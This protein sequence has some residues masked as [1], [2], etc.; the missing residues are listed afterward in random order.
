MTSVVL[1]SASP[2]RRELIAALI[3][4]FEVQPADVAEWLD[5]DPVA[6]AVALATLKAEAVA[7]ERPGCLVIAADTIVHD[8]ARPYGKPANAADAAG[9][10]RALRGRTHRVV[11]ALAVIADGHD[12]LV[13]SATATVTLA[14]LDDATIA[15]Y[16]ASGRPLDKAGA[17]AIQDDDVPTV[18]TMDGCYC[19]VVGL[20]LWCLRRLLAARGI[21]CRDPSAALSRCAACP[22]RV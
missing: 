18:A 8:G 21:P 5:G 13:A 6:N 9:M 20:P 1:A 19:A 4:T 16:V 11:T 7:R 12:P 3:D 17:Y 22:D 14:P 2:R 15:A 10:L